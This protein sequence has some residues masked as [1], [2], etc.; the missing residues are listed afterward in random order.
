MAPFAALWLIINDG[1]GFGVY[2]LKVDLFLLFSV[3]T[4]VPLLTF[5]AASRILQLSTIGL[6]THRTDA[7]IIGGAIYS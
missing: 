5:V 6:L 7:S 3:Y 1:A 2:G 4:A